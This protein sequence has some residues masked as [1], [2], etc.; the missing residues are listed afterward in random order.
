MYVCMYLHALDIISLVN[1]SIP[2]S[3][4]LPRVVVRYIPYLA[5]LRRVTTIYIYIY[6]YT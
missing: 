6:I 1:S 3:P 5:Y 2:G 4:H